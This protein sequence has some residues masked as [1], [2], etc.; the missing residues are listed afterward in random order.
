[1]NDDENAL[2]FQCPYCKSNIPQ[3]LKKCPHCNNKIE[4]ISLNIYGIL[5]LI[6]GSVSII[7]NPFLL[8][9][10]FYNLFL[11]DSLS[12]LS[13][14]LTPITFILSYYFGTK[15]TENSMTKIGFLTSTISLTTYVF[16]I[17]LFLILILK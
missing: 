2:S 7:I 6:F 10:Q 17:G 13:F 11:N 15:S 14:F 12:L 1:M 9:T 16:L 5:S 4:S 3:K 8:S